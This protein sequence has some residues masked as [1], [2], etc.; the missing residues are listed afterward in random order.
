MILTTVLLFGNSLMSSYSTPGDAPT[1]NLLTSNKAI[2]S[3][4]LLL[5]LKRR[6]VQS[7]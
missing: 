7:K 2:N 6:T 4:L 3:S 1:L 5:A